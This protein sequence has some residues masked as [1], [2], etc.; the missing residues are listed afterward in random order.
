MKPN[1]AITVS[2][3]ALTAQMALFVVHGQTSPGPTVVGVATE[4][5]GVVKAGSNIERI[6]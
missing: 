2:V 3:C 6:L 5:Q 1:T 4:I